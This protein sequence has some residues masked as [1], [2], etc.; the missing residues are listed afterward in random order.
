MRYFL[1]PLAGMLMSA[2]VL[3]QTPT[4]SFFPP[5]DK[6]RPLYLNSNGGSTGVSTYQSASAPT[7]QAAVPAQAVAPAVAVAEVLTPMDPVSIATRDMGET[8]EEGLSQARVQR[9][10]MAVMPFVERPKMRKYNALG[11][12]ISESF[13]YQLQSRGFNLVDYRAVSLKTT[14]KPEVDARHLSKLRSRF[15]IYFVLTG[16][17]A[18]YPDGIVINARV[19]DTTT[20]QVVASGQAHISNAELE[21]ELPGY[22]PLT[23]MRRGMIIENGEGAQ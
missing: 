13:I 22:D 12:R 5:T 23:V 11:E 7:A 15:R 17:Y 8:L 3:A 21:G 20:R 4:A 18:R 1:L 6:E 2:S 9:L 14:T 10:P 19:L 16:T